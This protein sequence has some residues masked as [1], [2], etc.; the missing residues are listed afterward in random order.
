MSLKSF[1]LQLDNNMSLVEF[2]LVPIP[3]GG[4]VEAKEETPAE[5]VEVAEEP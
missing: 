4:A 1:C 5:V 3:Q 2:E